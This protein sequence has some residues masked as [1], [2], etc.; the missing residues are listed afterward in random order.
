M[1][2]EKSYKWLPTDECFDLDKRTIRV[3]DIVKESDLAKET[4]KRL[5]EKGK[6]IPTDG[7]IA[8]KVDLS[9]ESK[10]QISALEQKIKEA[11]EINGSLKSE[12]SEKI[13]EIEG[14]KD[15]LETATLKIADL[16]ETLNTNSP[17][18]I[19]KHS[20]SKPKKMGYE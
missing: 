13:T 18:N 11:L 9:E 16:E 6:L 15:D 1:S 19:T 4:L 20:D 8:T 2:K 14:L 10:A 5:L 7:T 17:V 3:G 12:L